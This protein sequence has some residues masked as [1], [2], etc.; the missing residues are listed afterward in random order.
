MLR[1][2]PRSTRTDTPLPYTT[3]FR[4]VKWVMAPMQPPKS[5]ML[6]RKLSSRT[7]GEPENRK[8]CGGEPY[9]PGPMNT[10]A[11]PS[12]LGVPGPRLSALGAPAGVTRRR[13][14]ASCADRRGTG[15]T[16]SDLASTSLAEA[17]DAV[18]KALGEGH[19]GRDHER[20]QHHQG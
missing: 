3:L 12:G 15:R 8:V 7:L 6:G 16:V 5:R 1:G 19:Q 17:D 2:P 13:G 4:S 18:G 10:R 9:D 14:C 11:G 20:H